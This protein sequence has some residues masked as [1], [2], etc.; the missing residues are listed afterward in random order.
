MRVGLTGGMASGK[1]TVAR[2]WKALGARVL[3]S[4]ETVHRLLEEDETV[5]KEIAQSFG[6]GVFDDKGRVLRPALAQIVFSD[7]SARQRLMEILHPRTI[8]RHLAEAEV[9]LQAH[10]DGVVVFDSPLLFESGLDAHMDVTVVVSA[11]PEHQIARALARAQAEGKSLSR[12]EVERR[13]AR[14]MPLA[15]KCRRATY[16]L[17]NN[18]SLEE[19]QQK[20][21]QL[22]L[23]LR[24]KRQGVLPC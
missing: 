10:P 9:H 17:E 7:E 24:T 3:S 8:A 21:E 15:E 16:V 4:D 5:K 1:S 18:G 12:E 22:W 6:E 20:A 23:W 2:I 14:Q 19:L 13:L 11:S